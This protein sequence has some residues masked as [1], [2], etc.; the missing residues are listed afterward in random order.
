MI[1][2]ISQCGKMEGLDNPKVFNIDVVCDEN[3]QKEVFFYT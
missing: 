3:K 2:L 1:S